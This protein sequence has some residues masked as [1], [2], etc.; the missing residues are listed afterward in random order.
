MNFGMS[1]PYIEAF[2][3]ARG[4]AAKIFGVIDNKPIINASKGQGM[5][6]AEIKGDIQFKDVHFQ[7]PSRPD[8]KVI[9][10]QII[11]YLVLISI[12]FLSQILQGLKLQIKAGETVALVGTSGCGK[13]TCIQLIQRFYDPASGE[14][15]LDG[16]NLKDLDLNWLRN[17]IGVVGQEPILFGA[18]IAENIKYGNKDATIKDIEEAA[19][20]ANADKFINILP[21]KYDTVIGERGAQL[22]GGQKQRIAIARALVRNPRILLLD[23]ATS[24]LDTR[25]ESKVQAALDNV[26]TIHLLLFI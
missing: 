5:K 15:L 11:A 3:I 7:Y 23:E 10:M 18:S 21:Q 2:S 9:T 13:S 22:S 1:S 12:I 24:A 6:P 26:S 16:N 25:S 20:A 8:V 19:I 14:V 4:A 17:N